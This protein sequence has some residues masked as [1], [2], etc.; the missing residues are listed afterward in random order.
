MN[1]IFYLKLIVY[2]L[3]LTSYCSAALLNTITLNHKQRQR[4]YNGEIFENS[5]SINSYTIE[6]NEI[7]SDEHKVNVNRTASQD[8]KEKIAKAV[9]GGAWADV[10]VDADCVFLFDNAVTAR[11]HKNP[12]CLDQKGHV[13]VD[14]PALRDHYQ[15]LYWLNNLACDVAKHICLSAIVINEA[16]LDQFKNYEELYTFDGFSKRNLAAW[17]ES[18]RVAHERGRILQAEKLLQAEKQFSV[19]INL[20]KPTVNKRIDEITSL[21]SMPYNASSYKE[22][23]L[24]KEINKVL[25]QKEINKVL[26]NS[27]KK[28]RPFLLRSY[29][30]ATFDNDGKFITTSEERLFYTWMEQSSKPIFYRGAI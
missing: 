10:T 17:L 4:V 15:I 14:N 29:E 2:S 18:V 24:K 26:M 1:I 23:Q 7:L 5:K 27:S 6:N 25:L 11:T 22:V 16:L 21:K 13:H 19:T 20:L 30:L 3:A 8:E 9:F 12:Y 28:L